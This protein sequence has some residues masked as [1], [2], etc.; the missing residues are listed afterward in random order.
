MIPPK[1]IAHQAPVHTCIFTVVCD[2]GNVWHGLPG[3]VLKKAEK[4]A[5]SELNPHH[6]WGTSEP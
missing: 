2:G 3:I 4:K 6:L 1:N 5:R